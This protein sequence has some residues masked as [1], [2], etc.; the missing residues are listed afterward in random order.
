MKLNKFDIGEIVINKGEYYK[1]ID[2]LEFGPGTIFYIIEE[3]NGNLRNVVS[4][5]E[6]NIPITKQSFNKNGII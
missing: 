5:K 4:E 3:L 1:I 6:I 2:C